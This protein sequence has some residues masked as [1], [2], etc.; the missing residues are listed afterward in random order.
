MRIDYPGKY[1]VSWGGLGDQWDGTS[2]HHPFPV[3]VD[4]FAAVTYRPRLIS[5]G[6]AIRVLP[7]IARDVGRDRPWLSTSQSAVGRLTQH[8][9]RAMRPGTAACRHAT[10]QPMTLTS[11]YLLQRQIAVIDRVHA[12]ALR[13]GRRTVSG[14]GRN[15]SD[16][17]PGGG[18]RG[19][20][21]RVHYC[22]QRRGAL[23]AGLDR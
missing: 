10:R 19:S 12:E 2:P 3:F 20:T 21:G 22:T 23:S 7:R 4:G 15:P 16:A 11:L 17:I 6:H 13:G 18:P 5:R 1:E 14:G 9:Y 8:G